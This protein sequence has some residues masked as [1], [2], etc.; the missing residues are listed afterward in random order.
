MKHQ[1]YFVFCR[2]LDR[3]RNNVPH[4]T[5]NSTQ[6]RHRQT[7]KKVTA[8]DE[9]ISEYRTYVLMGQK[10]ADLLFQRIF[11]AIDLYRNVT[12]DDTKTI[13]ET[14]NKYE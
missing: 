3:T 5:G 7:E 10:Q 2:K 1:P 14:V 8:F 6:S 13:G 4:I 12:I 9:I 11:D